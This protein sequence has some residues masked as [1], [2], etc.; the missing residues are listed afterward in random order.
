M[1]KTVMV[2]VASMPKRASFPSLDEVLN[3]FVFNNNLNEPKN[4]TSTES[5][6]LLAYWDNGDTF[7]LYSNENDLSA[8]DHQTYG[9]QGRVDGVNIHLSGGIQI[10]TRSEWHGQKLK[11]KTYRADH[12]TSFIFLGIQA[13]PKLSAEEEYLSA[14]IE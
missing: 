2:P 1:L 12:N 13:K 8:Y 3:N 7:N 14:R 6:G 11:R 9:L 10:P 4:V 5:R